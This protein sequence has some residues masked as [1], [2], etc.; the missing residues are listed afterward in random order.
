MNLNRVRLGVVFAVSLGL[1]LSPTTL[2]AEDDDDLGL[3]L[4]P[5]T[6]PDDE[7][8]VAEEP[9]EDAPEPEAIE[10]PAPHTP[11]APEEEV[12]PATPRKD[13]TWTP[14][15]EVHSIYDE[16]QARV[17]FNAEPGIRSPAEQ[18]ARVS[19]F[20]VDV[21]V[22]PMHEWWHVGAGGFGAA[23]GNL[24]GFFGGGLQ[25]GVRL[26][27]VEPI[28]FEAGAMLGAGG[29]SGA[30]IGSG[31]F[32]RPRAGVY[33]DLQGA[34]G[35]IEGGSITLSQL[36]FPNG[37]FASTHLAVSFEMGAATLM[38]P[39]LGD[40][41]SPR[42][43]DEGYGANT[44]SFRFTSHGYF[45][46]A[47][48]SLTLADD[49]LSDSRMLIGLEYR[50]FLAPRVFGLIEPRAN[51][52]GGEAGFAELTVGAGVS[53]PVD[54][55]VSVFASG[56]VGG[57]GGGGVRTGGGM[58]V[59]AALGLDVDL[60]GP[61]S[62]G[63]D[64]GFQDAPRGGSFTAL[65]TG[66]RLG[67]TQEVVRPMAYSVRPL[68]QGD[69]VMAATWRLRPSHQSLFD[70]PEGTDSVAAHLLGLKADYFVNEHLFLSAG[71]AF[72]Y[73]GLD[74]TALSTGTVALGG[75]G[76]DWSGVRLT[77]EARLGAAGGGGIGAGSGLLIQPMAG[78]NVEITEALSFDILGGF[79]LAPTGEM[80]SPAVDVGLTYAF[81]TPRL[82]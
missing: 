56:G 31:F 18:V 3:E 81:S 2:L 29:G 82:R 61:F 80:R 58:Y 73:A 8:P 28:A 50:E 30:P 68:T 33:V 26:E 72:A 47:G 78:A 34:G 74:A 38:Y 67:L 1:V 40:R 44:R 76:P 62:V 37:D 55:R 19:L 71:A 15:P 32:V 41:T 13:R 17:R 39:G 24:G 22:R 20:G 23:L 25:G 46:L 42:L 27:L 54:E 49:A 16:Y 66:L 12:A 5:L 10:E 35:Y 36:R 11:P 77:G 69:E 9:E 65:S 75:I 79:A 7:E 70:V 51:V 43:R 53:V 45:P 4:V 21:D 52:A 14:A 64:A 6:R 63:V 59:R 60:P 48:R 57:A